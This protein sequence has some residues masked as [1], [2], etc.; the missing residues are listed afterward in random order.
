MGAFGYKTFQ[1]DEMLDW[2]NNLIDNENPYEYINRSLV[3]DDRDYIEY[4]NCAKIL[5]AAEVLYSMKF[6]IRESENIELV[7]WLNRNKSVEMY[8]KLYKKSVGLLKEIIGKKSEL[9]ELWSESSDY[10]KWKN[11]I[12]EMIEKLDK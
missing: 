12:I 4:D 2:L 5:G 7:K 3:I 11:Y 8:S 6:G 9:N 1:D 10:E